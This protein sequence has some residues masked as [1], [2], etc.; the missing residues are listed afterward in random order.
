M[1]ELTV[2]NHKGKYV[3]DS[4][5]VAEMVDKRHADLLR[6]IEIYISYLSHNADL[7]SDDFFIEDSY[8]A[9]TG[10]PYKCYFLTRKGCD[11]VANKMTGEKGVIFTAM[12]VTKFE[13]MENAIKESNFPAELMNDPIIAIRFE[14]I[15]MEQRLAAVENETQE[16]TVQA[17]YAKEQADLANKRINELDNVDTI[18]DTRQRLVKTVQRYAERNGYTYS[19]GWKD[20]R[21]AFNTAFHTNLTARRKYYMENRDI[22]AMTIP[23]YLEATNQLQD[24]LRVANKMLQPA[25]ELLT[26]VR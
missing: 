7:R 15:K 1:D 24:A 23:E 18:G 26:K 6:D 12:Y 10:K 3:I 8:L 2:I 9:G 13:E 21:Q 20:F 4:R 22:K 5:I 17:E 16:A 25:R 19:Q 11:M 14:Q